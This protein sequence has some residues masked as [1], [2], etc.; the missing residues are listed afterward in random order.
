MLQLEMKEVAG[1]QRCR[2]RQSGGVFLERSEA[3]QPLRDREGIAQYLI[4]DPLYIAD[5]QHLAQPDLEIDVLGIE[6][7]QTVGQLD[8]VLQGYLRR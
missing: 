5:H 6:L 1:R 8:G 2:L 4:F 3:D 7:G